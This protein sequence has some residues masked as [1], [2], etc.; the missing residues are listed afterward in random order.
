MRRRFRE[1]DRIT[2]GALLFRPLP[3][4]PAG[5]GT[6]MGFDHYTLILQGDCWELGVQGP[7]TL[8]G[9]TGERN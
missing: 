1:S 2:A 5:R 7:S 3:Y 6:G 8:N 4:R 9:R